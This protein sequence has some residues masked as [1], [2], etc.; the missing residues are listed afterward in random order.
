[1][2]DYCKLITQESRFALSQNQADLL[3]NKTM[4]QKHETCPQAMKQWWNE[5]HILPSELNKLVIPRIHSL[6]TNNKNIRKE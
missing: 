4:K 2:G 5:T 3:R 1:M 6:H